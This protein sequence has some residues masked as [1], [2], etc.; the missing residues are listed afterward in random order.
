M[1]S[2]I[3][4]NNNTTSIVYSFTNNGFLQFW[5]LFVVQM[6]L[7]LQT[8]HIFFLCLFGVFKVDG[9]IV[10]QSFTEEKTTSQHFFAFSNTCVWC[11]CLCMC[12]LVHSMYTLFSFSTTCVWCICL[13]MCVL[14]HGVYFFTAFWFFNIIIIIFSNNSFSYS[15][16]TTFP[17][18]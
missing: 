13:C 6:L 11:I 17:G 2:N 5:S 10:V 7:A 12:V 4:N 1:S 3:F 8:S 18:T 15:R 9:Q 14:V 16:I